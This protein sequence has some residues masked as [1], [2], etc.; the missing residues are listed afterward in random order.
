[1]KQVHRIGTMTPNG[2]AIRSTHRHFSWRRGRPEDR[3][4]GRGVRV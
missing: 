1:M 4:A 2:Y 3:G